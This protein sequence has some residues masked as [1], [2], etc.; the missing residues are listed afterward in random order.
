MGRKASD[1]FTL[2]LCRDCHREQHSVGET[3]FFVRRG[4]DPHTLA[5]EFCAAS[6]KSREIAAVKA[7]RANG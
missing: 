1:F 3:A 5:A 7:E 4:I 2:S 6:P